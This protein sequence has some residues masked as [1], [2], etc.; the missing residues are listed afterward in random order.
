MDKF[1]QKLKKDKSVQNN[2]QDKKEMLVADVK[3][4]RENLK[5]REIL[6]NVKM[7]R[8]MR[9]KA[10]PGSKVMN[11][12]D[13]GDNDDF[14]EES[15]KEEDDK[16]Q[17]PPCAKNPDVVVTHTDFSDD[18]TIGSNEDIEKCDFENEP[19]E[20][21]SDSDKNSTGVLTSET[22][23]DHD[24]Y[25]LE[26]FEPVKRSDSVSPD[27]RSIQQLLNEMPAT[28]VRDRKLSLDQST[29]NRRVGFTQS[30]LDLH[31]LGKSPLERKSS[32]FRK[33]MDSFLRNTTDLFKRQSLTG[34]CQ[35]V[36]RRGSMSVSLQSLNENCDNSNEG[37][38]DES[39]QQEY[40]L[41][42][43]PSFL[44]FPRASTRFTVET[45]NQLLP[46]YLETSTDI[47]DTGSILYAAAVVV[48]I[49]FPI[50][51]SS[52]GMELGVDKCAVLHVERDKVIASDDTTS[53][54]A[55]HL[56]L[57]TEAET[58][59]Y[60]SMTQNICVDG[61]SVKQ[62]AVEVFCERITKV[63]NSYFVRREQDTSVLY[64]GHARFHVHIWRTQ[65]D[66]ERTKRPGS[67]IPHNYDSV[68]VE[69]PEIVCDEIIY[70]PKVWWSWTILANKPDIVVM[71]R[72]TSRIFLVDITIP[73]HDNLVKAESDKR[74]K[75]LDLP[76]DVVEMRLDLPV[77]PITVGIQRAVLLDNA[78][79]V[80]R[81]PLSRPRLR[82][83]GHS[84]GVYNNRRKE[85]RPSSSAASLQSS[86]TI[87]RSASSLSI[88]QNS[89]LMEQPSDVSLSGSQPAFT[90]ESLGDFSSNSVHSLNE[91]YLQEAMLKSRA[92]SMSSG[93]DS[94]NSGLRR[95]A[96]RSNRVTWVASEGLTNYFRRIIQDEKSKEIQNSH[97]YQDFS[98]IPE[99]ES[100]GQKTDSKGRRLSY[101]R[102]VSGE[103]PVLPTRYQD[104]LRRRHLILENN[105]ANYELQNL[106]AEFSKNGVPPLQGFVPATIPDEALS[107]LMWSEKPGC[108][109]SIFDWKTLS[110]T[111]Q[112]KQAVIRELVSTEAD[113]IQHLIVIVEIFI[114]AAHAL[115]DHGKMLEVET[116][117]LFSNIPDLLNANLTFW[118]Y[119]FY[120]MVKE[121]V[122]NNEPYKSELM[123]N[124]FC[125]FH[126]IFQPYEKYMNEQSKMMDYFRS[127][128]TDPEFSTYLTWCYTHKSCNRLQLADLL[129]KPMQRLT[130]Y[131]LILSRVGVYTGGTEETGS[132]K[133]M[134]SFVK[135]YV[136]DL[137][138]SMRQREELEQLDE[139]AGTIE[140]YELE[141]KDEE[142]ER[143]FK[144]NSAL[145][146]RHPMAHCATSHYRSIIL[147]SE[148]RFKDHIGKEVEARVI[149][150][151]DLM[152]I[153]KKQSKGNVLP[154]KMIRPKIFLARLI[155][156]QR[157]I[158]NV[159]QVY[160]H[161]FLV[162]DDCGSS[163][164][165]F[166]LT[167]SSKDPTPAQSLKT[168]ESKIKEAKMSYE[169]SMWAARNPNRDLSEMDLDTSTDTS[170]AHRIK[171]AEETAIENEAR[172]R[173]ATMLHRSMGTSTDNEYSQSLTD[174]IEGPRAGPSSTH[175][176]F[177]HRSSTASSR[178]SRLSSFQQSLSAASR[179]D[180]LIGPSKVIYRASTS[181]DQKYDQPI[182][183]ITVNVVNECDTPV[184]VEQP[185]PE[186]SSALLAPS[187][188]QSS[189]HTLS[190]H[191]QNNVTVLS[192]QPNLN[193]ESYQLTTSV[194]QPGL[195]ASERLYR[196]HQE[197]LQRNRLAA[198]Q[199]LSP[200]NRGISYPPPS[201]TRNSL[202][203][204]LA[205]SYSFKNPPLS[206]MGNVYSQHLDTPVLSSQHLDRG[207]S[208]SPSE[209]SDKKY[210]LLGS[211]SKA[212]TSTDPEESAASSRVQTRQPSRSGD[213]EDSTYR[214][215]EQVE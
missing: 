181:L 182:T 139:L 98:C 71:Y 60:L 72:A 87:T 66:S 105:E 189:R 175:R 205:F 39:V 25:K 214:S 79:I 113:Y 40:R 174:S 177:I 183:S 145:N 153:C 29:L 107:Y 130:K 123:A 111:E 132:L 97:S 142:M 90:S 184:T 115:Q 77:R 67:E 52:I 178:Q 51:N 171:T 120:P 156:A 17:E 202:K 44:V 49:N 161:L 64:L 152:M 201:P 164:G 13:F 133:A 74:L 8:S 165:C 65:V 47:G 69:S 149:L 59:R 16:D 38:Q 41:S 76:H 154:Y 9:L 185:P 195:S 158:K 196:S 26:S 93:L 73:H 168:L 126:E 138:R 27:N 207:P 206:K 7:N 212:T 15:L 116:E 119:T 20:E 117:R 112:A 191:G 124:G 36:Q 61:T 160:G 58:Y 151:T 83:S 24:V 108:L 57:L 192:S 86:S 197:L 135:C 32:F 109:E 3:C 146:L 88:C 159:N 129:V 12:K 210:K 6:R 134:E 10:P 89:R 70:P 102:A 5:I 172:E 28:K 170:M 37:S 11:N 125:R 56:R 136:T 199:F 163:M 157:L 92:I 91:A 63:F 188:S 141:F 167:E 55:A 215:D 31:S 100:F 213:A 22:V 30:E 23:E 53:S 173:V 198:S 35:P 114:A 143:L 162:V 96:S 14:F 122:E 48:G 99:N 62:D 42:S 54:G 45:V 203:R 128:Q 1:K 50:M 140:P 208:P 80:R 95:K 147:D 150:L 101:Q 169:M 68:S 18:N 94:S 144:C 148:F 103:D 194:S 204:G 33:K 85:M 106:L 211:R 46:P 179:D 81:F 155:H 209:K 84:A 127:I 110:E 187:P 34:K 2:T 121:A 193:Q 78:R 180:Q 131:S 190:V 186:T 176:Q 118:N 19:T 104:T 4:I 82:P 21:N 75:Y 200:D 166:S 43:A 137:N